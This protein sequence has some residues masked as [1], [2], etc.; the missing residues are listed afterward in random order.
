MTPLVLVGS[1]GLA[2]EAAEAVRAL[3]ERRPTYRLI[4]AFDDDPARHSEHVSGAPVLGPVD[5]VIDVDAEVLLC[6]GSPNDPTGRLRLAARLDLPDDRYAT[7]VHPA[8]VVPPSA[9]L[10]PGCLLL[11]GVV[12]TTGVTVG[13]H[14]VAMPGLIVTHDDSVGAGAT[15]ASGVRLSGAVSVDPGAYL[16][17][18]SAVLEGVRIGCGAVVGLGS[19]VLHDVGPHEVHVGSPAAFLRMSTPPHGCPTPRC[20][21]TPLRETSEVVEG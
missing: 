7:V 8:A 11:A 15:F 10:M 20:P 1:G 2:R 9:T 12:L 13:R 17:A 19:V 3:N 6:T 18:A 21:V 14:V 5:G 4:G 16:G